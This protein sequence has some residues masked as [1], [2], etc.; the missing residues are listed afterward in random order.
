MLTI[1]TDPKDLKG[2]R[3]FFI[4]VRS[5]A[6]SL[7]AACEGPLKTAW[8]DIVAKY[9]AVLAKLP[10]D[11]DGN[12][13]VASCLDSLFNTL[14]S[15]NACASQLSLEMT[16]LRGQTASAVE[17]EVLSRI[18]AGALVP[19]EKVAAQIEAA[20]AAKVAAGELIAK[21]AVTQLCSAAQTK[22]VTEGEAKVRGEIAAAAEAQ[23]LIATRKTALTTAG[24]PLPDAEFES[25]LLGK[26]EDFA[27]AQKLFGDRK[28]AFT[29]AGIQ[30]P[31]E[32]MANLWL[33]KDRFGTFEKTISSI[34]AFK[35]SPNPLLRADHAA[36]G[37]A[38]V[39]IV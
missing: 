22:G 11:A 15:S 36:T 16:K 31:D 27:T 23:K 5:Q 26:D 1:P 18:T 32:L 28:V 12:W 9:D 17:A 24:L 35:V 14:V 3:D 34:P 13:T 38:K 30:I 4:T 6:C 37:T 21:E 8:E 2:F 10:K 20:V 29:T 25:L 7:A 33:P 39:M 19:M